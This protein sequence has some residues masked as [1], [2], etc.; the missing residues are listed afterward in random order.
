[1]MP[2]DIQPNAQWPTGPKSASFSPLL[3]S[4]APIYFITELPNAVNALGNL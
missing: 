4:P 3:L 2:A 1:M